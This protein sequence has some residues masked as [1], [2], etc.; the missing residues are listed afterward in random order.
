[1]GCEPGSRPII[2]NVPNA[3]LIY[4]FLKKRPH[5]VRKELRPQPRPISD[6]ELKSQHYVLFLAHF[7]EFYLNLFGDFQRCRQH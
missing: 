1:M 2:F 4:N 5:P 6:T 3:K 7:D